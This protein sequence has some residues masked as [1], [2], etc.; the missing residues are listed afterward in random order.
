MR[1]VW[2]SPSL[3]SWN[4]SA[5]GWKIVNERTWRES[6]D[7]WAR[8][9]R[10]LRTSK[11]KFERLD[12][13]KLLELAIDD[14]LRLLVD[15]YRLHE[16]PLHAAPSS[17]LELLEHLSILKLVLRHALLAI[18][19]AVDRRQETPPEAAYIELSELAWHFLR[20]TDFLANRLLTE[21]GFKEPDE[22]F[23][24]FSYEGWGRGVKFI[25]GPESSWILA[26]EGTLSPDYISFSQHELWIPVIAESLESR[27]GWM[28]RNRRLGFNPEQHIP[29]DELLDL[30][31]AGRV[32][33]TPDQ[34]L[35]IYRF[36]FQAI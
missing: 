14:R 10:T 31:F 9:D 22:E 12:G 35:G 27:A 4:L 16:I 15:S 18:R 5:Q 11:T 13:L 19:T 21:I 33:G 7:I 6:Y 34:E 30:F 36:Y 20:A 1:I 17:T 26:V 25:T 23:D 32:S 28:Q 29:H 2:I 3:L 8:A 24:Y